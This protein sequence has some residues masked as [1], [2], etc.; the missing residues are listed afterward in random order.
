MFAYLVYMLSLCLPLDHKV[1]EN[2]N[3]FCLICHNILSLRRMLRMLKTLFK[4]LLQ[5]ENEREKL[6]PGATFFSP[7]FVLFFLHSSQWFRLSRS[8]F[9]FCPPY[10]ITWDMTVFTL[11]QIPKINPEFCYLLPVPNLQGTAGDNHVVALC[12]Y[13]CTIINTLH[14]YLLLFNFPSCYDGKGALSSVWE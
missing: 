1:H 3:I 12:S 14:L 4:Y 9:H 11:W 2:K 13:D 7:S 5:K 6:V 10:R 8:S